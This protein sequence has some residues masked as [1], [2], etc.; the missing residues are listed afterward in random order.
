[1]WLYLLFISIVLLPVIW[2]SSS[3]GKKWIKF[4]IYIAFSFAVTLLIP[5]WLFRPKDYRNAL[6][7]S[8][9]FRGLCKILGLKYSIEGQ[10]HIVRNSGSVVL[11]NHQSILDLI[12]LS[13][14]WPILPKCTV[15]SKKE[16]LYYVPIG[17]SFWL[18]GT[19]FI[20]RS[21]SSNAQ[22]AVN[23]TGEIIRKTKSRVL[24]FPE[25]TRNDGP[26]L[27]PFKKGA[28]HLAVASKCP[29]QP[30]AVSRFTFLGPN[31]FE[32]G[33][34]KIRILPAIPTNNCTVE[35]IPRLIEETYKT[36]SDNVDQLST[37]PN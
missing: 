27:L 24:I 28:F 26:K 32:E 36:M 18:C 31:K 25:G 17:L 35:D 5:I 8:A 7:P 23:K 11:I 3:L 13:C 16:I 19:I 21:K 29:I 12:V 22:N 15:I 34:I 2:K 20:D 10:E 9:G 33:E 6:L 37:T 4:S 30:V 14:L 1:M